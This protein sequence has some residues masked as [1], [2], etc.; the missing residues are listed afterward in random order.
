M[1]VPDPAY[2]SL[3]QRRSSIKGV[4]IAS[5]DGLGEDGVMNVEQNMVSEPA[6]SKSMVF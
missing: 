1:L 3:P 6:D 4:V 2:P 5:Q